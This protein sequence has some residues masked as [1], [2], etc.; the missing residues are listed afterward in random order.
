MCEIWIKAASL[1]KKQ[2]GGVQRETYRCV[3]PQWILDLLVFNVTVL[4]QTGHISMEAQLQPMTEIFSYVYVSAKQPDMV[5][6]STQLEHNHR[7]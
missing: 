4:D 1:Y 3:F 2:R 6:S 5:P 7:C